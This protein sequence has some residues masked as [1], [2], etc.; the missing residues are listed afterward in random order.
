MCKF[1]LTH[2]CGRGVK[3][4]GEIKYN[5]S[6]PMLFFYVCFFLTDECCKELIASY[7]AYPIGTSSG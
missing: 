4:V 2:V 7:I 1:S 6:F 3:I 5:A